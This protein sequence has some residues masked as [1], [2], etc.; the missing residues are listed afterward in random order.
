M[1]PTSPHPERRLCPRAQLPCTARIPIG[2]QWSG[3]LRVENL[4]AGGA[5]LVAD[6]DGIR[7]GRIVLVLELPQ[8]RPVRILAEV[9]RRDRTPEGQPCVALAFRN[10]RPEIEDR[11]QQAVLAALERQRRAAR[12]PD[13]AIV[14]QPTAV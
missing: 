11:I 4:S 9:T 1:G 13:D 6:P 2:G 3:P 10:L 12:G 7:P 5:L 14:D 8:R